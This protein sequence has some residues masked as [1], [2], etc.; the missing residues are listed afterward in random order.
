MKFED[1]IAKTIKWYLA[2]KDWWEE[3]INGEYRKYYEKM[4]KNK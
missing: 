3:I 4:Y 2:H 1:G